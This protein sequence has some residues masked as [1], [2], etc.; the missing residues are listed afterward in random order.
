MA[1]WRSEWV[2]AMAPPLARFPQAE[3]D[4]V[5]ARALPLRLGAMLL[6][7]G[8]FVSLTTAG[9]LAPEHLLGTAAMWSF[10]PALQ[11][12][13]LRAALAAGRAR[14]PFRAALSRYYAGH[15]PWYALLLAVAGVCLF[16]PDVGPALRALLR[17]GVLPVALLMALGWGMAIQA[18]LLRALCPTRGRAALAMVAFYVVLGGSVAGWYVAAGALLPLFG[19]FL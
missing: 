1:A 8:A 10:L 14:V 13:A 16:A 11:A 6:V 5:A 17:T 4:D 18:A 15:G 9:R 12:L 2:D 7:L 19:V 3:P